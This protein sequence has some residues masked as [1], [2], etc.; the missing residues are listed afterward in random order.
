MYKYVYRYM[1]VF[2]G[3][4]PADTG[5]DAT[6]LKNTPRGRQSAGHTQGTP[7]HLIIYFFPP[8]A[9]VVQTRYGTPH[10]AARVPLVPHGG[11]QCRIRT[12]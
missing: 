11:L 1:Y 12:L 2:P 4:T 8:S 9:N 10:P 5:T 6:S 3:M 7:E